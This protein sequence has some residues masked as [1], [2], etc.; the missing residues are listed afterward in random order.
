MH[1]EDAALGYRR[2]TSGAELKVCQQSVQQLSFRHD[3][4]TSWAG[5]LTLL[6]HLMRSQLQC[7]SPAG[8]AHVRFAHGNVS[9]AVG[10][11]LIAMG[12]TAI[13]NQ[14]RKKYL[15]FLDGYDIP[16]VSPDW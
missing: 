16:V 9:T 4:P 15:R 12:C 1:V 6:K 14:F 5:D 7:C 13:S 8:R 3:G 2:L 11:G 10:G